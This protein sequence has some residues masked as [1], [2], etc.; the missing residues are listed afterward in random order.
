MNRRQSSLGS[1]NQFF[2]AVTRKPKL[3]TSYSQSF[4][5]HA[6]PQAVGSI[7]TAIL[8]ARKNYLTV[9]KTLPA[10]VRCRKKLSTVVAEKSVGLGNAITRRCT[11]PHA[12]VCSPW[13]EV[14]ICATCI[15]PSASAFTPRSCLE[16]VANRV[17]VPLG[18]GFGVLGNGLWPAI[19]QYSTRVER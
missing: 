9:K 1:R 18:G 5:Y 14:M 11:A 10:C 3:L 17:C 13:K 15:V 16:W 2:Q 8:I 6:T 19:A 12:G 4:T 7:A